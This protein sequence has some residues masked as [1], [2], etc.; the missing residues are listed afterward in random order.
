MEF[1]S[2][3]LFHIAKKKNKKKIVILSV[4][5]SFSTCCK[6]K[7]FVSEILRMGKG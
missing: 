6:L 4:I 5:Q 2:V 7:L 3:Q 1:V